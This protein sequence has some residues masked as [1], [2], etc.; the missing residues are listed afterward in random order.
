[1]KWLCKVPKQGYQV[2]RCKVCKSCQHSAELETSSGIK[3]STKTVRQE[4]HGM[5][6]PAG[7]MCR[8]PSPF[9]YI[10]LYFYMVFILKDTVIEIK[11]AL[12]LNKCYLLDK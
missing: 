1:M 4:L 10:L 2:L 5:A 7:V 9:V 6:V 8:W 11:M 12:K 3:I